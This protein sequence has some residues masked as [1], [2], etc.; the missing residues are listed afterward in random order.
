MQNFFIIGTDSGAGVTY[1]T[2]ALLRDLAA[3]GMD[4]M[5]YKPVACGD[6]KEAREIRT[7]TGQ[8]NYRLEAI[9]PVYLRTLA[10][11][12]VAAEFEHKSISLSELVQGYEQ[13][14]SSHH[15]V[16]TDSCG[17]WET[18]LGAG[19]SV[20]HL[21]ETLALPVII[22]AN[23]RPGA[24]SL[25]KLTADA[26]RSRGLKCHGVILNHISEEWSTA[27][28]TNAHVI[29]ELCNLPILAELIHG[30]DELDSCEILGF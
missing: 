11:P 26:I 1:V 21:A 16:L 19:V 10:E 13:L 23:N 29:S 20:A 28:V 8:E 25:V 30:Q 15:I 12:N 18:P 17:G 6:R 27:S 24:A 5:G 14:A 9:N 2:C 4:A 3:R 22:V 7:A